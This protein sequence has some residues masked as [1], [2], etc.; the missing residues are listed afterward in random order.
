[1]KS[2]SG[3]LERDFPKKDTGPE[4]KPFLLPAREGGFS[5]KVFERARR[6]GTVRECP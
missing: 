6:S 4:S 1:M 3:F 2:E 5:V